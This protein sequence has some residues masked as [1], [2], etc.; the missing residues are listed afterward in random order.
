M[1]EEI[2]FKENRVVDRWK[3]PPYADFKL[4]STTKE[5]TIL[6]TKKVEERVENYSKGVHNLCDLDRDNFHLKK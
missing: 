5:H 3:P 2:I 4:Q 6:E 1:K